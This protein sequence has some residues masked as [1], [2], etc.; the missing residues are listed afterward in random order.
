MYKTLRKG[1]S[2]WTCK[3]DVYRSNPPGGSV[4]SGLLQ[5][6]ARI[7]HFR[8][9]FASAGVLPATRSTNVRMSQIG[10]NGKWFIF[11]SCPLIQQIHEVHKQG[12]TLAA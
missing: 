1:G 8:A 7:R 4:T 10:D 11:L 2:R 6:Q 9:S 12:D 5:A 3:I